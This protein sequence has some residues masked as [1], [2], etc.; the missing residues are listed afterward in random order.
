MIKSTIKINV[1]K[2]IIE[3][4]KRKNKELLTQS[5]IADKMGI[6]EPTL[7]KILRTWL[8]EIPTFRKLAEK[9]YIDTNLYRIQR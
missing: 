7:K 6:S 2:L 5:E 4:D 9:N 3:I 1:N 8:C